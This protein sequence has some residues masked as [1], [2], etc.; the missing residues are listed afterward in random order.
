MELNIDISPTF[1]ANKGLDAI[2]LDNIIYHK[3]V[4]ATV[5]HYFKDKYVPVILFP[6]LSVLRTSKLN[7]S[8]ILATILNTNVVPLDKVVT[9]LRENWTSLTRQCFVKSLLKVQNTMSHSSSIGYNF[10]LHMDDVEDYARKWTQRIKGRAIHFQNGLKAWGHWFKLKS[11]KQKRSM[12]TRATSTCILK[13]SHVV[14][15]C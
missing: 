2:N 7:L 9:S 5:P 4:R 3:L 11:A 10:K 6:T 8:M 12:S 13:D 14:K 1:F 15:P